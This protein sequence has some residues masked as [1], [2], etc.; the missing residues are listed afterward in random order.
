MQITGKITTGIG[1][2]KYY[3]EKY[4]QYF[5]KHLEFISYPGTL[6]LFVS[7]YPLLPEDKKVIIKPSGQG[8]V[9]CYPIKINNK[10]K[11]AIIIP[12]KTIH[13]KEII[14]IISPQFLREEYHEGEE[15]KCELV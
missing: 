11:G 9:D 13:G 1:K 15:I 7:N 3:V 6:N 14:E 12:H 4:Q 2:G 10:Y 5:I 8:Q